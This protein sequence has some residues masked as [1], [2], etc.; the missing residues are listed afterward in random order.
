MYVRILPQVSTRAFSISYHFFVL[1][2]PT[3]LLLLISEHPQNTRECGVAIRYLFYTRETRSNDQTFEK[4]TSI[5]DII[6]QKKKKTANISSTKSNHIQKVLTSVT[7]ICTYYVCKRERVPIYCNR[8]CAKR[9]RVKS[10]NQ[11]RT[12][13][14]LNVRTNANGVF[15]SFTRI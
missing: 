6:F 11:S 9:V 8:M 14:S 13:S 4:S 12:L 10:T 2:V 7:S 3:L 5:V 15:F 1:Q